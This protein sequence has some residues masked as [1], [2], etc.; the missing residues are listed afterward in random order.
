MRHDASPRIHAQNCRCI[1][2]APRSRRSAHL[3]EL[4]ISRAITA[5]FAGVLIGF[6]ARSLFTIINF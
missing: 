4:S 1:R 6:A 5:A 3:V 2:C